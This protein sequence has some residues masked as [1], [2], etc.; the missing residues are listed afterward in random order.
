[1]TNSTPDLAVLIDSANQAE[2]QAKLSQKK[3]LVE[4]S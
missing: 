4:S 1:L 3:G 2:R